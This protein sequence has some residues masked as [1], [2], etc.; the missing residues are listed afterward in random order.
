[1]DPHPR[2]VEVADELQ[3]ETDPQVQKRPIF[4]QK[5]TQTVDSESQNEV[6]GQERADEIECEP[7]AD[8]Q[9][10]DCQVIMVRRRN[11]SFLRRWVMPGLEELNHEKQLVTITNQNST[12]SSVRTNQSLK[13]SV[14]NMPKMGH[15]LQ[16]AHAAQK[17]PELSHSQ[18]WWRVTKIRGLNW[19]IKGYIP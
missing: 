7:G 12:D 1:M 8:N 11:N 2:T 14:Y 4:Y 13:Y 6:A 5:S 15:E 19:S 16:I 18:R 17:T 10:I 9:V 3:K